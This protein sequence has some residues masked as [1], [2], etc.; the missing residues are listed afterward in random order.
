MR[1]GEGTTDSVLFLDVELE[2]DGAGAGSGYPELRCVRMLGVE[3]QDC[4]LGQTRHTPSTS[5]KLISIVQSLRLRVSGWFTEAQG[6]S[7]L[8]KTPRPAVCQY[9][10]WS[11][12]GCC[13]SYRSDELECRHLAVREVVC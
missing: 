9:H 11:T 2:V 13:S 1:E 10:T 5:L 8:E 7:W 3:K 12:L 4:V 6:Q